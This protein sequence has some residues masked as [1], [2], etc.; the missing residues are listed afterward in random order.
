M[1]LL[2]IRLRY[3]IL[4]L[5]LLLFFKDYLLKNFYISLRYMGDFVTARSWSKAIVQEDTIESLD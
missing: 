4:L 5:L 3:S 2:A 1:S